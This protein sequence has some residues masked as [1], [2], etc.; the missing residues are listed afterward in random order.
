[1]TSAAARKS[2]LEFRMTEIVGAPV[3]LTVR[4]DRSF[5]FST[6]DVT[7]TIGDAVAKFFGNFATVH[8]DHDEECGSF[9]YVE[10]IA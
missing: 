9:A 7:P 5:T 2:A 10:V 3:S 6:E 1:M 8:V 4:G